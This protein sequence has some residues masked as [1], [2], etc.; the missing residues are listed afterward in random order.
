[1]ALGLGC[2]PA[3][4]VPARIKNWL[5]AEKLDFVQLIGEQSRNTL[6]NYSIGLE[7][8]TKINVFQYSNK[9]DSICVSAVLDLLPNHIKKL[10][11]KSSADREAVF[12]EVRFKLAC[13]DVAVTFGENKMVVSNN[14]YFDGL[15]KDRF[16]KAVTDIEKAYNLAGWVMK[17]LL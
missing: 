3:H 2:L 16:F 12:S 10:S 6:F 9:I 4:V 14:I 1:M 11:Q 8:G 15:T 13:L 17:Q 5:K 7:S